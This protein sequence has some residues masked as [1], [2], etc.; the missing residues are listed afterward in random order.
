MTGVFPLQVFPL[1]DLCADR[2]LRGVE[3]VPV[4]KYAQ[5]SFEPSC[6]FAEE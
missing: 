2:W 1:C 5:I 6:N 3:E 4:Q